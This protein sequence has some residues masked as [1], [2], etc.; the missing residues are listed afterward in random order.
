ML[1]G[2][3]V[4]GISSRLDDA[5]RKTTSTGTCAIGAK[6][7]RHMVRIWAQ[8]D[9]LIEEV[10]DDTISGRI[11]QGVECDSVIPAHGEASGHH[12]RVVG[13]VALY[14]DDGLASDVP[15]A[16]YVGHLRVNSTPAHLEHEE[17]APVI[18]G[19]GSY[20]VRRQRQL[21]PGSDALYGT[22]ED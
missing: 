12:H 7:M 13:S 10:A 6:E 17:H 1:R 22:Q 20:R 21:E 2:T 16:L 9:I 5:R 8:G 3:I 19:K 11:L 15:A 18:L 4:S 14:R